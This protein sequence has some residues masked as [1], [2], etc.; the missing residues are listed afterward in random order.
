MFGTESR[1]KTLPESNSTYHY[2]LLVLC[3]FSQSLNSLY[4]EENDKRRPFVLGL[5][6]KKWNI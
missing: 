5:F 4:L 6:Y 2:S 3:Y 1:Q